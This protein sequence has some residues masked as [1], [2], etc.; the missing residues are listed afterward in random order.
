MTLQ[1]RSPLRWI[2]QTTWWTTASNSKSLQVAFRAIWAIGL[3][4]KMNEHDTKLLSDLQVKSRLRDLEPGEDSYGTI[5]WSNLRLSEGSQRLLA[6][7]WL[8]KL[9][10][11]RSISDLSIGRCQTAGCSCCIPFLTCKIWRRL[12]WLVPEKS[13]GLKVLS[14]IWTPQK[15]CSCEHLQALWLY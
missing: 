1:L 7:G 9:F 14:S 5:A 10:G 4:L 11:A 15:S 2:I 8:R 13:A 3:Q 12:P 6:A